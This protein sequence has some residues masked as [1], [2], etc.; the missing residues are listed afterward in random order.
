[1]WD[2]PD[3][4]IASLQCTA[5]CL[6]RDLLGELVALSRC[7]STNDLQVYVHLKHKH[8]VNAYL[9]IPQIT[10]NTVDL[11]LGGVIGVD[12]YLVLLSSVHKDYE[13]YCRCEQSVSTL[14]LSSGGGVHREQTAS[15]CP[16][17]APLEEFSIVLIYK[18]VNATTP[19]SLETGKEVAS[20]ACTSSIERP[21]SATA[22]YSSTPMDPFL[23]QL[24]M[25]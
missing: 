1:M 10:P 14:P 20:G 3:Y 9:L 17:A 7:W 25:E 11:N 8:C 23:I 16:A 12:W 6:R 5:I 21:I 2:W 4:P 18:V 24:L 22:L 13:R 19:M 15:K